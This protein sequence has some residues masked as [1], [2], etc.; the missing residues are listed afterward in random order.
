MRAFI[1]CD[2]ESKQIE[3]FLEEETLKE[4]S[5]S[6]IDLGKTPA[7]CS[8]ICQSSDVSPFFKA[9]KK[10]LKF[11]ESCN[12]ENEGLTENLQSVFST[13]KSITSENRK[14]YIDSLEKIIFSIKSTLTAEVIQAG[15]RETG[16]YPLN[17]TAAMSKSTYKLTIPEFETMEAKLPDVKA[18]FR[19][20]GYV[21]EQ[22]MDDLGIASVN[23]EWAKPKDEK[24]LHQQRAVLINAAETIS[25]YKLYKADKAASLVTKNIRKLAAAKKK[26][27]KEAYTSW[28]GNLSEEEKK[29]E[30]KR[31]RAEKKTPLILP[32]INNS[33][34]TISP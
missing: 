22:Q 23:E 12:Y 19:S 25:K 15:Y 2:G 21:T 4:I 16:Q 31:K 30:R 20:N 28:F 8:G 26:A 33:N 3:V 34:N 10:K 32:T 24:V 29:Q 18:F 27:E 6:L 5:D 7:S 1:T 13:K 9:A 17:L 14:K 11:V